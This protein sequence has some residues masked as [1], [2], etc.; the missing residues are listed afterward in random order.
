MSNLIV[1][2]LAHAVD[3]CTPVGCLSTDKQFRDCAILSMS[4]CPA[5][6][7]IPILVT[8]SVRACTCEGS[9]STARISIS[10]K[11]SAS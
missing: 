11:E 10:R 8:M 6:A 2:P 9:V 1:M 5:P 3:R 7:V 4:F